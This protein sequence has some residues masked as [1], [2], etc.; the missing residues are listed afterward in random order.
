MIDDIILDLLEEVNQAYKGN[1][2]LVVKKYILKSISPEKRKSFSR[3]D[4]LT[5]KH[6]INKFENKII[7]KYKEL[8]NV[9]LILNEKDKHKKHFWQGN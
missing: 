4:Y 5:K 6:T 8:F 3:R 1:D 9:E 2:W 7:S